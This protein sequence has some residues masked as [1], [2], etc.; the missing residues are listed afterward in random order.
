MLRIFG[1]SLLIT[2]TTELLFAF[3]AGLRD[4]DDL[5]LVCIVNCLTNPIAVFIHHHI[6]FRTNWNLTITVALLETA[7]IA[8]EAI[9]FVRSVKTIK[10]PVLFSLTA[11]LLS[12]SAG[13]MIS[14]FF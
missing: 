11:N 1:L 9:F 7:V 12:F 8:A 5:L 13:E 3:A 10:K 6:L 2:V 14:A 4:R